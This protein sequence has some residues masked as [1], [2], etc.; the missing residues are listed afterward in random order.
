MGKKKSLFDDINNFLKG[1]IKGD[2][3]TDNLVFKLHRVFTVIL[4]VIFSI[5]FSLNQV[6]KIWYTR[7]QNRVN[8]KYRGKCVIFLLIAASDIPRIVKKLFIAF[9]SFIF[10]VDKEAVYMLFINFV[11]LQNAYKVVRMHCII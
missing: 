2:I 5:V 3:S 10:F 1:F 11:L 6:R 9:S 7:R 4:L 8:I